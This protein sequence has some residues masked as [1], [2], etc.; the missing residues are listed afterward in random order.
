MEK[1]ENMLSIGDVSRFLNV[2]THT[3][4]YWEKEFKEFLSPARTVGHQ[5]RY[6]DDDVRRI[7]D[8]MRLL[9]H[10]GYS[11]AGAKKILELKHKQGLQESPHQPV[12]NGI[13]EDMAYK[14]VE[15]IRT[16]LNVNPMEEKAAVA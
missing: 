7:R 15:M 13:P 2:P 4:R 9:K 12:Q 11:I 10:D 8:I 14:I 6:T 3:I 5:R 1:E 16:Q